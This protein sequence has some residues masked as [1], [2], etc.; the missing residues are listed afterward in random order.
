MSLYSYVLQKGAVK[1]DPGL[2][3]VLLP[4]I[5]PFS[6][7]KKI[8]HMQKRHLKK[9]Q[10]Q[11]S[12]TPFLD[13]PLGRFTVWISKYFNLMSKLPPLASSSSSPAPHHHGS[14]LW[15]T[16]WNSSSSCFLY[17]VMRSQIKKTTM[18]KWKIKNEQVI[19]CE[20]SYTPLQKCLISTT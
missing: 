17:P 18:E 5:I 7:F 9:S 8:R 19:M 3:H 20:I 13:P 15:Q 14:L 10:N 12:P 6:H 4:L 11:S 16:S 1:A 2:M